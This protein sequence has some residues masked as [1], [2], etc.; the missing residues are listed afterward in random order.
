MAR[1]KISKS[2]KQQ[3]NDRA[4]GCC[5][6]CRSQRQFSPS[7]FE[8]EHTM[9]LSRGGSD[10]LENLALAC[11]DYNSHFPKLSREEIKTM[12]G[13]KA[14]LKK[15]RFYQEIQEETQEEFLMAAVPMG[16]QAGL[17]VAEI[18]KRFNLPVSQS[19]W[20]LTLASIY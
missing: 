16:L 18:A 6:Y 20:I 19:H 5:E 7:G 14:E 3:V 8:I 12:L 13:T 9:P 17:S 1:A 10:T 2:L 11:G 4:R 15:T